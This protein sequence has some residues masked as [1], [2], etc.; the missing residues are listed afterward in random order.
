MNAA[1]DAA[2]LDVAVLGAAGTIAGA[3]VR[4]LAE[5][6][7]VARLRLLD[8]DAERAAEVARTH[9]VRQGVGRARR[10]PRRRRP[11]RSGERAGGL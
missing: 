2:L 7:E 6:P 8:L 10:R 3:I 5:S 1:T 9:G 4:D 11:R